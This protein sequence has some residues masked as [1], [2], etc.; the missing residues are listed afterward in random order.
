MTLE[1]IYYIGQ[2]VA[3]IAIFSSLIFVGFQI[4][5]NSA[6]VR[7]ATAQA[8]HDNYG[9]WYMAQGADAEAL[10]ASIKGFLDYE[11]LAPIEKAHFVCT[12]MA[13]LSHSQNAFYQWKEGHLSTDLWKGWEA[14]MMNLVNT[15]GGAAFWRERCYVFGEKFQHHVDEIMTRKP[16]PRARALGVVPVTQGAAAPLPAEAQ[17]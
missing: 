15:P 7:S 12:Y 5:E 10:S 2:T 9:A 14:L 11:G 8:V 3:V 17:S 16:D 13:F 4:R 1:N 6:A